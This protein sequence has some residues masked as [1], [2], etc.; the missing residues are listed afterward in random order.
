MVICN[1]PPKPSSCFEMG[2]EGMRMAVNV[3][4]IVVVVLAE[5]KRGGIG[6]F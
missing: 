2:R 1:L 6:G 4:V 3:D 5:S